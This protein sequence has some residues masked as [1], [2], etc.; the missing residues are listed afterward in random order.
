MTARRPLPHNLP[1][2]FRVADALAAGASRKRLEASDLERVFRGAR[3]SDP[4]PRRALMPL[5]RPDQAFAGPTAAL[6]HGMPLPRRR[7]DDPRLHVVALTGD[8]M[9]RP[10]VVGTRSS[11]GG[12]ERVGGVRVLDA[13]W[14]WVS[15]GA[16]LSVDDLVAAGDRA[17]SGTMTTAG[18]ATPDGLREAIEKA[19]RRPGVRRLRAAV[20]LI[21]VG[22]WSRPESLLRLLIVRSG[23]P[24]PALNMRIELPGGRTIRPDL[25]WIERRV[26]VEYDGS[27]FHGRADWD[28]DAARH[29]SLVDAGWTVVRVRSADLFRHPDALASRLR[30]RFVGAS[31]RLETAR[32]ER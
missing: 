5:L 30:Q 9:R 25:A 29:E 15:L 11:V 26:A 17:V 8:R 31:A 21:R 27:A 12:I 4:D 13:T 28:A 1:T 6:I 2:A 19:G 22:A 24:E 32:T 20:D 10:G 16:L 23:L 18:S 3:S 7:E 14:T